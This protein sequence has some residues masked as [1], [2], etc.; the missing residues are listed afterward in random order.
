MTDAHIRQR[1]RTMPKK[2]ATFFLAFVASLV[3]ADP[4]PHPSQPAE[5]PVVSTTADT[6]I[7]SSGDTSLQPQPATMA[8]STGT[9][10][11]AEAKILRRFNELRSELLD[12][13]AKTVDWWLGATAVFLALFGIVAVAAGYLSFKRFREIET[14]ARENMESSRKHAEEAQNLVDKIKKKRDEAESHVKRMTAEDVHNNPDGA[15]EAAESVRDNPTASAIDQAVAAAVRFQQR[16]L[17]EKSIAKWRAVAIIMEGIDDD[18]AARAWFS[19]GYIIQKYKKNTIEAVIDAYDKASRLKP[20]LSEA[21]NNRGIAKNNLGRHKEAIADYDEA[22]RLNSVNPEAYNNRGKTNIS[23]NRIGE[24][25]RDFETAI[26]LARDAG[27]ET[28]ANYAEH[29]LK[30]LLDKQTP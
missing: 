4:A 30:E 21:Y 18:L 7:G 27:N 2:V 8:D 26:T 19:V 28:L 20:D 13:R 23:L 11:V 14:E 12:H 25:R 6:R 15:R 9:D 16:E 10:V 29:A 17:F 24:A 22:I 1:S 5:L 3:A